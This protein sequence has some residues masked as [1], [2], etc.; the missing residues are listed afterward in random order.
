MISPF[1]GY[2]YSKKAGNLEQLIAPPY[3]VIGQK[4]REELINRSPYN[5]VRLTLPESF[6]TDYH[7][8]IAQILETWC[9]EKILIQ[10]EKEY[11]YLV[12]QKFLYKGE[13]LERTGLIGL[14]DLRASERVIKHEVIFNK[15]R[16]DRIKLLETTKS[17]LEPILLLY[18]D[19]ENLLEEIACSMP[20][21]EELSFEET[22]VTFEPC[23]PELL[24]PLVSKIQDSK[25]FIADGHHRF[26]ASYQYFQA[27]PDAPPF[28]MVYLTNFLSNSLLVLP[29]HRA[30]KNVNPLEKINAI[31]EFFEIKKHVNLSQTLFSIENSQYCSFGVYFNNSFQ[32]WSLKNIE[33]VKSSLPE[34]F[35]DTLKSLDV[36]IL[37]YL[38]I[39][40]IFGVTAREKLYYD[41]NPE[42]IINFV[43]HNPSSIG[44][45]MQKPNLLKI[46]QVASSGEILPPKTTFFYPKVPSGLVIARYA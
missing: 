1:K 27:C 36:V 38:V 8:E 37:H 16:D 35:S 31:E 40:K 5:I 42:E 3:D 41:R 23:R 32:T 6:D 44:F 21:Q 43:N 7:R 33:K 10:D 25:L 15:Y 28:I 13:K 22:T 30:L 20:F 39:E 9:R 18:E 14:F 45:F 12:K 19:Q 17:N 34:N 4:Y 11:F 29:T 46:R 26:Q 2:R 24:M